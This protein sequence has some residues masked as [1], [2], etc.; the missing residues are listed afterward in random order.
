MPQGST[1]RSVGLWFT[2][3][4]YDVSRA[5]LRRPGERVDALRGSDQGGEGSF[6]VPTT[7]TAETTVPAAMGVRRPCG[8]HHG[9]AGGRHH[10]PVVV[11]NRPR[12]HRRPT[13]PP[14]STSRVTRRRDHRSQPPTPGRR[15][16]RRR[17]GPRLQGLLGPDPPRLLRLAAA[18]PGQDGRG[19]AADRRGHLRWQRCAADQGGR[20]GLRHVRAGVVGRVRAAGRGDDGLPVVRGPHPHLGRNSQRPVR[21]PHAAADDPADAVLAEAAKRPQSS[22]ST[23]GRCSRV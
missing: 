23:R 14:S 1:V 3:P 22:S 16:R 8:P 19:R 21:G 18:H 12:D 5:A 20:Q 6:D 10:A 15:D 7:T 17:F 4:L 13:T 9:R 11:A 2:N